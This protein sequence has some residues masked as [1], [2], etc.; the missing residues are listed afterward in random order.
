M[1]GH[2]ALDNELRCQKVVHNGELIVGLVF[3]VGMY[4]HADTFLFGYGE[5]ILCLHLIYLP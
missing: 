4:D 5:M 3:A 2:N 1:C